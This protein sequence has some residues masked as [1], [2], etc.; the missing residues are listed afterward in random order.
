MLGMENVDIYF[1]Q[2]DRLSDRENF[3]EKEMLDSDVHHLEVRTGFF[4]KLA[5]LAAG[6]LALGITFL[7]SGYQ[8][9]SL[10]HGLHPILFWL[11]AAMFLVLFSLIPCVAHNYLISRAVTHLSKQVECTYKAAHA[12]REYRENNPGLAEHAQIPKLV[13]EEIQCHEQ[14]ATRFGREKEDIVKH[15]TRVGVAAV[16]SLILGF[17]IGLTGVVILFACTP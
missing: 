13:R 5:V 1:R 3:L 11:S 16:V 4:D 9:D 12:M 6:S 14:A 15:A 17:G 10:R 7:A 8:N 2:L